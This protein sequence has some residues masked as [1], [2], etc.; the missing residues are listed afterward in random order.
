M[1]RPRQRP[2]SAGATADAGKPRRPRAWRD[3]NGRSDVGARWPAG[4]GRILRLG[5]ALRAFDVALGSQPRV[6]P[7]SHRSRWLHPWA[8]LGS[9]LRDWR[10]RSIAP[11]PKCKQAF[12][13]GPRCVRRR[14]R[15]RNA[16][17]TWG[18]RL[19]QGGPTRG[20]DGSLAMVFLASSRLGVF[21][22]KT[23]GRPA[24]RQGNINAKARRRKDA[25][26]EISPL[27]PFPPLPP[28]HF[29]PRVGA[30]AP[31]VKKEQKAAEDTEE[32][33]PCRCPFPSSNQPLRH[34]PNSDLLVA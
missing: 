11:R 18:G 3:A 6:A 13:T 34:V 31:H 19:H 25:K 22:L 14:A 20:N 8:G 28:V 23:E 30:V 29:L 24:R 17:G 4:G 7:R 9:S 1:P 33:L 26:R 27:P 12:S 2:A 32:E 10:T 21:A 5:P 16:R 15:T